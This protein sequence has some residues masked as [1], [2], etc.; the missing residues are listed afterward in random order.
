MSDGPRLGVHLV[1][2]APTEAASGKHNNLR[3]K[4]VQVREAPG[5]FAFTDVCAY[6]RLSIET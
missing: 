3:R 1:R 5:F 6:L 2:H 4:T